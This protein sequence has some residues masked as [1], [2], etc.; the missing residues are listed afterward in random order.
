MMQPLSFVGNVSEGSEVSVSCDSSPCQGS[1][2]YFPP[3]NDV[4]NALEVMSNAIQSYS[5]GNILNG[6]GN[7]LI[8]MPTKT[9]PISCVE[10]WKMEE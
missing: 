10:E 9:D 7:K 6:N 8:F 3:N 5:Y 2:A 1:F 4:I